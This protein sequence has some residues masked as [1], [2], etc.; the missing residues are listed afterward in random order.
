MAGLARAGL[1][2]RRG[3][4][5]LVALAA[6]AG[7]AGTGPTPALAP[8]ETRT[9]QLSTAE[10]R[11]LQELVSARQRVY[12]MAAPLLV[13]NAE[14]CRRHAR[15]LLGF[16][17]RNSHSFPEQLRNAAQAML[18][19]G[20]RLQVSDVLPAS[21]AERAGLRPGDALLKV[22]GLDFPEGEHA[23]REAA[24]LLIP[25]IAKRDALQITVQRNARELTLNVPL[26]Q[27]CAFNIE[28]GNSPNV[29]AYGDGHRILLTRGMLATVGSDEEL[30]YVIARE[31]A[32]GILGHAARMNQDATA[33]GIIDNLVRLQPDLATMTGMAG[34]RPV[35]PEF[36]LAADKLSVYLL[37]RAG[38]ALEPVV[39][40]WRDLAK[41]YPASVRNGYTALHPATERRLEALEQAVQDVQD[42]QKDGRPLLPAP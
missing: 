19:V 34:L 42:R 37:A 32:H 7:C 1:R 2:L 22:E 11:K 14:L 21:G 35:V 6:L 38:Y 9:A 39:P 10:I 24:A 18:G 13:T 5:V 15:P 12:R 4:C 33:G 8:D 16:R 36:D 41:R 17:A 28:I 23:D 30:A 27:A 40:F 25:L 29:N 3:W 26:T 31:M 20:D